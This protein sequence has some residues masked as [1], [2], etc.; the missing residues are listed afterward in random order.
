MKRIVVNVPDE[1]HRAIRIKAAKTGETVSDVVRRALEA[2][3]EG[4]DVTFRWDHG[5]G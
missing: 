5:K 2:W 1:V 4:P 3:V